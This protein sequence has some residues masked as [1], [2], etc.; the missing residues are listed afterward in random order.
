VFSAYP[1]KG[2]RKLQI[3]GKQMAASVL[4]AIAFELIEVGA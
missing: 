4:A 3:L 1:R 2:V